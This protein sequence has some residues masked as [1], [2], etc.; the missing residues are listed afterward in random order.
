MHAWMHG[1]ICIYHPEQTDAREEVED[2]EV[3]RD[4]PIHPR[5]GPA[6]RRLRR[7]AV[8]VVTESGI[9]TPP[10]R[11]SERDGDGDRDGRRTSEGWVGVCVW[12]GG[13]GRGGEG[14]GREQRER[15]SARGAARERDKK[16]RRGWNEEARE[17][18]QVS[19]PARGGAKKGRLS[20][21]RGGPRACACVC[22]RAG[23]RTIR[24]CA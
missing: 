19:T 5:H 4:R 6:H 2:D 23:A 15:E 1:C 14:R 12:G 3:E 13:G 21:S 9:P 18:E 10:G 11:Q 7:R 24:L 17:R 8:H 22:A 16:R 20:G